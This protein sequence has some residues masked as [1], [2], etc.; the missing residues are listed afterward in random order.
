MA[1][2]KPSL[3]YSGS[4]HR[5]LNTLRPQMQFSPRKSGHEAGIVVWWSQYSYAT[6]GLTLRQGLDGERILI[7]AYCLSTE[8]HVDI[9]LHKEMDTVPEIPPRL[10]LYNYASRQPRLSTLYPADFDMIIEET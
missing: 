6:L 8:K 9:D 3:C 1:S 10:P 2:L 5:I 4:K 7:M